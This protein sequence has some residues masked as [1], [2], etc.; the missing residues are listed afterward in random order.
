M[1]SSTHKRRFLLLCLG[2]VLGTLLAYGQV[3]F[4]DFTNFD[5]LDYVTAN[6]HVQG[7]VTPGAVAWAFTSGYAGN[8]HPLTWI[9]HMVDCQLWGLWPGGHHLTSL[10]LHLANT[11]L[12]FAVL[13]RMTGATG[14]SAVVAALFAWH[15]LHVESVAW[16]AERKDVLG[17]CFWLL[18]LLAYGRYVERP[19]RRRY[20][21]TL[22][23]FALGLL[24]KPM[25]V[26]LHCVLLLL[27]WWPLNRGGVPWRRLV[28]EK[29]PFLGLAAAAS[30]VTFLVEQSGGA[31]ATLT[32]RPPA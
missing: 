2:L 23:C 22:L 21:L 19:G 16:V 29:V 10:L 15:P 14:R 20:L 17:A 11:L 26:T 30:A 18:T 24:S 8:W 6:P 12:L 4:H 1:A 25:V 13:R 5:D 28:W 31:V 9:S 32:E 3:L 7:G 27:D